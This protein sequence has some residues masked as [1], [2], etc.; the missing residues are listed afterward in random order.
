MRESWARPSC[1]ACPSCYLS[2]FQYTTV[3][4]PA[5]PVPSSDHSAVFALLDEADA[6]AGAPR[7]R[8]LSGWLGEWRCDDPATL[9]A[10]WAGA[11]AQIAAGAHALLLADYEWGVRLVGAGTPGG[12]S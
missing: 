8:L 10:V 6:P 2:H 4:L 9:E 12:W 7:S 5:D 11:Q 1:C 3:F